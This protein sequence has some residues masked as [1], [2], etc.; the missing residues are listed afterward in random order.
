[1]CVFAINVLHLT[2]DLFIYRLQLRGALNWTASILCCVR[3]Y[4]WR[5]YT[6]IFANNVSLNDVCCTKYKLHVNVDKIKIIYKSYF[7]PPN[8][9]N[10]QAQINYFSLWLNKR[11][12]TL[13]ECVQLN[14]IIR[15]H[16][17]QNCQKFSFVCI[18]NDCQNTML[19]TIY[20]FPTINMQHNPE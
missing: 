3:K 19:I 9:Q 11:V 13:F 20:K 4:V 10:I 15:V 2:V 6:H 12:C 7:I 8:K 5:R 18:R 16:F 17:S 1:M 14:Y